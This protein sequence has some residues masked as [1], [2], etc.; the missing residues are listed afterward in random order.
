MFALRSAI[1]AVYDRNGKKLRVYDH[2][3]LIESVRLTYAQGAVAGLCGG[4]AMALAMMALS[5]GVRQSVWSMPQRLAGIILGPGVKERGAVPIAL[6]LAMHAV[7]SIG[8]GV[9]FALVVNRL[10]HE[11]WMTG[12]AYGLTLWV[13]NYWFAQLTPGGRS[14]TELKTSWL[15]PI[16]H[17]VYGGVMAAIAIAYAAAA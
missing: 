14:M 9:L 10:T 17:A 15:S 6:G 7:F 11:F 1:L 2:G 8:F 3:V 12:L 5:A 16:A 13:F 4:V